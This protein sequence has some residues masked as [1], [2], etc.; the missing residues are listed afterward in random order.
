MGRTLNN[1]NLKH[2]QRSDVEKEGKIRKEEN[3]QNWRSVG[4]NRFWISDKFS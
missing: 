3:K 2:K 1:P 4:E